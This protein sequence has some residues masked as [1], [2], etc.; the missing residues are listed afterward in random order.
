[1]KDFGKGV[2]GFVYLECPSCGDQFS[3]FLREPKN[4]VI[5]RN[6]KGHIPLRLKETARARVRCGKCGNELNYR[7]TYQGDFFTVECRTC[8]APV[9]LFMT[10][11]GDYV[12]ERVLI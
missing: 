9:D 3:I 6:C 8:G 2:K 12:S 1:M 5:C 7:T 10:A 4:D 11:N